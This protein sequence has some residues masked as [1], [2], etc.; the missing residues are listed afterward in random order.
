MRL[1]VDDGMDVNAIE[2][3]RSL[4]DFKEEITGIVPSFGGKCFDITLGSTEATTHLPSLAT[5]MAA[6]EAKTPQAP[7][8]EIYS[9]VGVCH[10]GIPQLRSH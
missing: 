1:I 8:S 9:C 5:T 6:N 2:I 7:W 10:G 4:P 3:F